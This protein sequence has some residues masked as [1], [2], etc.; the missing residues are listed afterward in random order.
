MARAYAELRTDE[1]VFRGDPASHEFIA[2]WLPG[3]RVAAA[4]NANIWDVTDALQALI[5]SGAR[6]DRA[7]LADPDVALADLTA[8][9]A[10]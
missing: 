10:P 1:V 7:R 6:V 4:M 3:G 9:A 2:F 5:R 8:G